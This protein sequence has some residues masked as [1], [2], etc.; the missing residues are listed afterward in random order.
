M[1]L[2][3]NVPFKFNL[4]RYAEDL[5]EVDAV[6]GMVTLTSTVHVMYFPGS[7]FARWGSL[8]HNTGVHSL[9]FREKGGKKTKTKSYVY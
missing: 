3:S 9:D 6:S 2:V 1:K 8:V 7:K 5:R 4:S